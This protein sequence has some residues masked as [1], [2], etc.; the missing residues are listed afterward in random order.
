MANFPSRTDIVT[1]MRNPS[2]SFKS[3]ELIGGSA[4]QKGS[5]VVQYSGGYTTVFPFNN[6]NA[7]KVA[8]RCWIADIGEAKVRTQ[9]ISNYLDQLSNPYF[10]GFKYIEDA[11]LINGNCHAI[12]VMDWVEGKT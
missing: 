1:A 11:V 8:I 6:F 3:K 4:I 12:V 9:E 10:V 5:R 2:V 7:E